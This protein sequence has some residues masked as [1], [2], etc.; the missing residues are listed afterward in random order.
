MYER[1]QSILDKGLAMRKFVFISMIFIFATLFF[2]FWGGAGSAN[3][4][5]TV[6]FSRLWGREKE[7]RD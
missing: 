2:G 3:L 7:K 4:P 5:R 6:V 1:K